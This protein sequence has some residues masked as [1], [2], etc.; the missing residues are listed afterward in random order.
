[1]AHGKQMTWGEIK[2]VIDEHVSDDAIVGYID[3]FPAWS[4]FDF[5]WAP[6]DVPGMPTTQVFIED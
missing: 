2:K 6:N 3:I 4:S 5:R 1:M